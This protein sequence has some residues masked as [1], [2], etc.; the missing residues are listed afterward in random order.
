MNIIN[1]KNNEKYLDE[2][3]ELCSLEW[4]T[5]KINGQMEEYIKIKKEK[6]LTED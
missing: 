6:I 2:Y 4:G 1:I 5:P 3:I